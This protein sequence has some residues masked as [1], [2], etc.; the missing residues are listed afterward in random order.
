M[1]GVRRR[2]TLKVLGK[3]VIVPT[4]T[5]RLKGWRPANTLAIERRL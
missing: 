2:A 5:L 4:D 3:E 1:R